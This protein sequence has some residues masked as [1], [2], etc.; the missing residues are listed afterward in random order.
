[1]VNC[2]VNITLYVMNIPKTIPPAVKA[3]LSAFLRR[4]S[5]STSRASHYEYACVT[6]TQAILTSISLARIDD[7]SSVTRGPYILY[8][9]DKAAHR[10][11]EILN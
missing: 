7:H 1:M 4:G 10:N 11:G 8:I 3:S 6:K 2:V 5:L 9:F